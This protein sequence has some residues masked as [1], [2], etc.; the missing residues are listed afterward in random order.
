M[1]ISCEGN[2]IKVYNNEF[3]IVDMD[4]YSKKAHEFQD[5]MYRFAL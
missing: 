4:D 1:P 3:L 2:V 5:D